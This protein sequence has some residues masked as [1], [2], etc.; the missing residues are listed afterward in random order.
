VSEKLSMRDIVAHL[1][2]LCQAGGFQAAFLTDHEG[3]PI[4]AAAPKRDTEA[5][6]VFLA[7]LHRAAQQVRH[8]LNLA[9]LDELSL[10]DGEGTRIV[11]RYLP[12]EEQS[13]FLVI[14]TAADRPYRRLTS[15][16]LRQVVARGRQAR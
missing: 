7:L 3:L 5:D 15:R 4:A 9:R 12:V 2:A 10:V 14:I 8:M 11:C 13:I 1:K 16:F 6:A